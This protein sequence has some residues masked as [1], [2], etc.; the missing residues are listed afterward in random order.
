MSRFGRSAW[1]VT[2]LFF[3]GLPMGFLAGCGGSGEPTFEVSGKVKLDGKPMKEGVI[4]FE[5]VPPDGNPP[6]H[7]QIADGA[8]T[9]RTTPGKKLVKISLEKDVEI[10]MAGEKEKMKEETLPSEY[11]SDS[12]I[13]REVKTGEANK[14]DFE[15]KTKKK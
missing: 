7:A 8:Y 1:G 6:A 13:H 12:K 2:V 3:A 11:N 5:A 9:L 4:Y 15:V 14:Y 10:D